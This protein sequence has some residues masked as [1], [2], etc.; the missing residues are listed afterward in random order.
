VGGFVLA[1]DPVLHAEDI[2]RFWRKVVRGPGSGCWIWTGAIGDDGYGSFSIRRPIL[3]R[4]GRA[5]VNLETGRPM[6]REHVVSAPRFAVAAALGVRLGESDIAEHAVCD[7]P[8]C[9]RAHEGVL[10]GGLAHVVMS[11]Q[12]ENLATMGR[13]GRGGGTPRP[14]RGHGP[15]RAA[16][17]ARSRALRAVVLEHGWD[18]AR[19]AEAVASLRF[20]NQGRLF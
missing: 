4:H 7:E 16:R 15:D 19:M 12:R 2:S 10:D 18:P 14:W 8:I 11:T 20:G 9:V 13:R 3:D 1:V 6:A 5:V 17:A